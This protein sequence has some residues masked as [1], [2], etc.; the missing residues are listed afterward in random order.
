M[1]MVFCSE[2]IVMIDQ[3]IAHLHLVL[4]N[5]IQMQR[6][7]YILREFSRILQKSSWDHVSRLAG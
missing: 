7:K 4:R 1:I 2:G 5:Q 6:A 3:L